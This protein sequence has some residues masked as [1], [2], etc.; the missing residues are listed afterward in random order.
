MCLLD[1]EYILCSAYQSIAIRE[2]KK[3]GTHN[4]EPDSKRSTTWCMC[5]YITDDD[6]EDDDDDDDDQQTTV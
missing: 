1:L 6:D 5:I 2:W 4:E 3:E